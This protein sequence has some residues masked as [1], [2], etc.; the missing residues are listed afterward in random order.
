MTLLRSRSGRFDPDQ[1][2]LLKTV[3]F[4]FLP[5][6]SVISMRRTVMAETASKL[7]AEKQKAEMLRE[8]EP[9]DNL[10]REI[11]RAFDAARR[12]FWR[13]PVGRTVTDI[14]PF[15]A[16]AVGWGINPAM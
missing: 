7:P 1:R 13:S 5:M 4:C 9:F 16:S 12:G 11:D 10:R 14:E 2:E 6:N 8:W 15:W 3:S